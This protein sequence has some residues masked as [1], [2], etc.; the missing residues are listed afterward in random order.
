MLHWAPQ[1]DTSLSKHLRSVLL[2]LLSDF[3]AGF[4]TEYD[5]GFAGEQMKNGNCDVLGSERD[6]GVPGA[7]RCE[8]EGKAAL[9]S[10]WLGNKHV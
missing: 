5:A 1:R 9:S 10:Y 7:G 6:L 8:E 4:E 2:G 3:G